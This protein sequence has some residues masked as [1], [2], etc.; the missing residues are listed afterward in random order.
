VLNDEFGIDHSTIQ[1][2]HGRCPDHQ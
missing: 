2:D 1:V